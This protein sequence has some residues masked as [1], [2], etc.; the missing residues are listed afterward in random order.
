MPGMF[1]SL[2]HLHGVSVYQFLVEPFYEAAKAAARPF[3]VTSRRRQE[4]VMSDWE[5][6]DQMWMKDQEARKI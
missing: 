1:R 5:D 6:D 4:S 3:G 2:D